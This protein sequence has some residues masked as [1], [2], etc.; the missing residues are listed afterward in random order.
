MDL[1]E[2]SHLQCELSKFISRELKHVCSN[3]CPHNEELD[4]LV[5]HGLS[6]CET[7]STRLQ[8]LSKIYKPAH[9]FVSKETLEQ[10][11]TSLLDLLSAASSKSEYNDTQVILCLRIFASMISGSSN[12][13][14]LFSSSDLDKLARIQSDLF[15]RVTSFNCLLTNSVLLAQGL[16]SLEGGSVSEKVQQLLM[17]PIF[18]QLIGTTAEKSESFSR[19]Y[20]K[21]MMRSDFP[22]RRL[23]VIFGV[24]SIV[25]ESDFADVA[26]SMLNQIIPQNRN[27]DPLVG[28]LTSYCFRQWS[29][30]VVK[31]T[32]ESLVNHLILNDELA[33]IFEFI[34]HRQSDP[35]DALREAVMDTFELLVCLL[36]RCSTVT[37]TPPFL[38]SL[39]TRVLEQPLWMRNTLVLIHR[40]LSAVFM[41]T[42]RTSEQVIE[43]LVSTGFPVIDMAHPSELS[44]SATRPFA[45][46]CTLIL[47]AHDVALSQS[48]GEVF[49]LLAVHFSSTESEAMRA[50]LFTLVW[51][52]KQL[53][54]V[55]HAFLDK[56]FN[57]APSLPSALIKNYT[58]CFT[59][60][61]LSTLLHAYRYCLTKKGLKRSPIT[62]PDLAL[63]SRAFRSQDRQVYLRPGCY[64]GP[65]DF[66]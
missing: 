36:V 43:W 60:E 25:S 50:W 29:I 4:M 14:W 22:S 13:K 33:P 46:G 41:E 57:L 26:S 45:L 38:H 49:A 44:S 40:F 11:F 61:G 9:V 19:L 37:V 39:L 35:I 63:L 47:T 1:T 31:S 64:S 56:V 55:S 21:I 51:M 3:D 52:A 2:V 6:L 48:A 16:C 58:Q 32:N 8:F 15:E 62:P 28:L 34:F 65:S 53:R 18:N 12:L 42:N 59:E 17:N 5:A 10:N 24:L 54:G 30:H 27:D 66:F 20:S 23:A 7:N